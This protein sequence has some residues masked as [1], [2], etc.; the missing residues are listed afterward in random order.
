MAR[1]GIRYQQVVAVAKEIYKKGQNPTVDSVRHIL[2]TG[3]RTTINGF[4]RQWRE[5]TIKPNASVEILLH[6]INHL[7]K[8]VE[9]LLALYSQ[10]KVLEVEKRHEILVHKNEGLRK[11]VY[12]MEG[13]IKLLSGSQFE[14]KNRRKLVTTKT[15]N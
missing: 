4:L 3:S 2:K 1:T 8:E 13:A 5:E 6:R 15:L 14:I 7:E 11:K 10:L 9:R 12:E